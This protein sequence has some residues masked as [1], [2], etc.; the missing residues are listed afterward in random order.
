MAERKTERERESEAC[1]LPLTASHFSSA[2]LLLR[3]HTHSSAVEKLCH[4]HSQNGQHTHTS[5]INTHRFPQKKWPIS[6][7]QTASQSLDQTLAQIRWVKSCFIKHL[8][9]FVWF[10]TRLTL[11]SQ[12]DL[13]CHFTYSLHMQEHPVPKEQPP[14]C[15][16]WITSLTMSSQFYTNLIHLLWCSNMHTYT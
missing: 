14:D 4:Q 2:H 6:F 15:L 13:T 10:W 5:L 12:T 7:S 11:I 16:I 1:S 8:L 3:K 9:S